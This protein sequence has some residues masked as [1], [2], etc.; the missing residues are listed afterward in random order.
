MLT[1][2]GEQAPRWLQSCPIK[3]KDLS[4]V[5]RPLAPNDPNSPSQGAPF[6]G[7]SVGGSGPPGLSVRHPPRALFDSPC[8]SGS[9]STRDTTQCVQCGCGD[10]QKGMKT[11]ASPSG[12]SRS[13]RRDT[14]TTDP[15]RLKT[16]PALQGSHWRC[17]TP[18]RSPVRV[19]VAAP[20][21]PASA[22]QKSRSWGSE[23]KGVHARARAASWKA[24]R[25]ARLQA[26]QARLSFHSSAFAQCQSG[27]TASSAGPPRPPSGRTPAGRTPAG[28]AERVRTRK[29]VD[30]AGGGGWPHSQ[31]VPTRLGHH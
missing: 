8:Q 10:G 14:Q 25:A 2:P 12:S 1:P 26:Q 16:L 11:W 21:G 28:R 24:G 29:P 22:A 27:T 5:L 13:S 7:L 3:C 20:G 15:T 6:W 4:L 31:A 19:Q 30:I 17:G 18:P 9:I 23:E